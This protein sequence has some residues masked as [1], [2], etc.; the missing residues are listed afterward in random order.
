MWLP[1]VRAIAWPPRRGTH[2]GGPLF[3][4]VRWVI[5]VSV[6]GACS[7]ARSEPTANGNAGEDANA[8]SGIPPASTCHSTETCRAQEARRQRAFAAEVA[9][10]P[11]SARLPLERVDPAVLADRTAG[12][13][14]VLDG[15]LVALDLTTGAERWRAPDVRGEA[16]W[17]AGPGLAVTA[18]GPPNALPVQLVDVR[19][20]TAARRCTVAV[21]GPREADDASVH[22]F[23]RRGDLHL[24]W[25]SR[26]R[27]EGGVPPGTDALDRQRRALACGV[28]AL[29]PAACT[30]RP[31][32]LQRY[33]WTSPD[34]PAPGNRNRCG[35]LS[36]LRD[37]PAAAASEPATAT[38]ATP[39]LAVAYDR[40]R[41]GCSTVIHATLTA[42]DG[43]RTLWRHALADRVERCPPP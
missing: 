11:A 43:D 6:A 20:P 30:V 19:A 34:E 24:A 2:V 15:S 17:R 31:E 5:A 42:T 40:T 38:S 12:V 26:Y 1:K 4:A 14:Y 22:P 7:A 10:E 13:A 36:P 23:D 33:L 18:E 8:G 41:D 9:R 39:K 29:D 37:L 32:P 16:L 3:A 21:P 35:W 28:L 27:Y 25:A